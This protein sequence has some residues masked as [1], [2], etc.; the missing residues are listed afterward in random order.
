MKLSRFQ[1]SSYQNSVSPLVDR[2][3]QVRDI[4]IETGVEILFLDPSREEMLE[5]GGN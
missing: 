3:A 1:A 2:F 4:A 5:P